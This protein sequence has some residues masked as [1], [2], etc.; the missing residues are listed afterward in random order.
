MN[1]Y[2]FVGNDP[3]NRVDPWGLSPYSDTVTAST[4]ALDL[5]AAYS[6]SPTTPALATAFAVS[7]IVD[8]SNALLTLTSENQ[9]KQ[10]IGL[11]LSTIGVVAAVAASSPASIILSGFGLGTAIGDYIFNLPVEGLEQSVGDWWIDKIYYDLLDLGGKC[12]RR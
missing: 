9:S 4:S 7:I 5:V 10:Y 11:T 6:K 1:L 12:Y 2:G 8:K 3:V